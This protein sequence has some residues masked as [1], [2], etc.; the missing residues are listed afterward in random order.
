MLATFLLQ[1]LTIL[2]ILANYATLTNL[3]HYSS[4]FCLF[5]RIDK[6]CGH[7]PI[8]VT[9]R[10]II[11][12]VVVDFDEVKA[13]VLILYEVTNKVVDRAVIL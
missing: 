12:S 11:I 13:A 5:C 2:F 7:L 1:D 9:N 6:S 3:I 4:L 8:V 10:C